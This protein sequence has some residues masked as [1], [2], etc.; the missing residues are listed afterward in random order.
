MQRLIDDTKSENALYTNNS[1]ALNAEMQKRRQ[2]S[3]AIKAKVEDV[4]YERSRLLNMI[5]DRKVDHY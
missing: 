5:R 2:R 3:T 4:L 1:E